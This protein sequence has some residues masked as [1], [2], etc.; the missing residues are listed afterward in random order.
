MKE[1]SKHMKILLCNTTYMGKRI[2]REAESN[3]D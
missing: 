3:D 1:K 2:E